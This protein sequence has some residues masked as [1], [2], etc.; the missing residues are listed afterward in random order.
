[1]NPTTLKALRASIRHWERLATGKQKGGEDIYAKSCALCH[2]FL[3]DSLDADDPENCHGCPVRAE[4]G[5]SGCQ[6]SPWDNAF[7]ARNAGLGSPRFIAAAQ[8][9]LAFLRSLLPQDTF[10][11]SQSHDLDA[12]CAQP[13]PTP[14]PCG[15]GGLSEKAT[16]R[17]PS[18]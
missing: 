13:A 5:H 14:T 6:F 7:Q 8:V 2:L 17:N 12:N 4:T 10:A 3:D 9:Q 11:A 1:M 16:Q 18:T 15:Q